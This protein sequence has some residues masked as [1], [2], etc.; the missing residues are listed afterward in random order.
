MALRGLW[1]SLFSR[2]DDFLKRARLPRRFWSKIEMVADAPVPAAQAS[3]AALDRAMADVQ[4][5][6]RAAL[7]APGAEET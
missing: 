1:G 4:R 6:I 5:G 3:A 2:R 7:S